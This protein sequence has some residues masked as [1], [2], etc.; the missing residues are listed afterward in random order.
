MVA[1]QALALEVNKE[2]LQPQQK[3]KFPFLPLAYSQSIL[4]LIRNKK[5]FLNGQHCNVEKIQYHIFEN[6]N[7]IR[8][9][10]NTISSMK[11]N[12]I[13]STL[14]EQFKAIQIFEKIYDIRTLM[15]KDILP[16]KF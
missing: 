12:A 8:L 16:G 1:L 3:H 4:K 5:F 11:I 9:K 10:L 2:E 14:S 13:H 15:R 6:C 7:P